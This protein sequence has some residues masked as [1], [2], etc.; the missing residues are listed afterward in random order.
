MKRLTDSQI[1]AINEKVCDGWNQGI[2]KEPWG[3]DVKE[4]G[5]VIYQRHETGGVS[6]GS[7]WDDSNPQAYSNVD[8]RPHWQALEVTLATVCP[9]LSY[10][11]YIE[12]EKLVKDSSETDWEY[13]GNCTEYQ[14]RYLPLETLY[15]H[16]KIK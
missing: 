12:I 7:C 16:L 10:S 13:C 6:G 3:I 5:F 9:N 8:P 14:I 15:K 11:S 4:K 1:A 2:F